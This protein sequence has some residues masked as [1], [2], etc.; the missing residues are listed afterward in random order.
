M[1]PYMDEVGA[2]KQIDSL[3]NSTVET[4]ELPN[5][6]TIAA[7]ETDNYYRANL[8]YTSPIIQLVYIIYA[9]YMVTM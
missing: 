9:I 8:L 2:Q 4:L 6:Y 1:I 5:K 7:V 3:L